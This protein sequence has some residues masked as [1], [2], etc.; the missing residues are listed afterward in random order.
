MGGTGN[1]FLGLYLEGLHHLGSSIGVFL[2]FISSG[3][4]MGDLGDFLILLGGSAK[5]LY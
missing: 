1:Y 5:Y 2:P 4:K 3:R